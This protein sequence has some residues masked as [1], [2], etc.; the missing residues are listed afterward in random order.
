[1]EAIKRQASKFREQVSRQQQALLRQLGH[2]G[3]E[4]FVVDEAEIA[5]RDQLQKLYTST[6]AAKHFE[7]DIVQGIEGI[8]SVTSKQIE[9]ERKFAEDCS[10]YET[11]NHCSTSPLA[12]TALRVGTAR[13]SMVEEKGT[14]LRVFSEKVC[15]PLR[16]LVRSAELEDARLLIRRYNKLWQE[17]EAQAA[18]V[19][20][21]KSKSTEGAK[22]E[23]IF[24]KLHLAEEKLDELKYRLMALGKEATSA[25]LSVEAQQQKMTFQH[26]VVMM[27]AERSYHLNVLSLLEKLLAQM[28]QLE[29][30]SQSSLPEGITDSNG[31]KEHCIEY[32]DSACYVAKVVHPFDAEA[33]GELSLLVD[34]IVVVQQVIPGGWCKG[35]CNG[36]TGCFPSPYVQRLAEVSEG[37]VAWANL[38]QL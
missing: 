36:K 38:Q 33:E 24:N 8:M 20:R 11:E 13:N 2:F 34:D 25:M 6:R 5:C 37:N 18:D 9:I 31:S 22:S 16:T 28:I 4:A 15:K 35:E 3:D 32:E 7:K 30:L 26:L 27:K 29:Q 12:E 23:E 21:L 14:L 19:L 1:M 10:R 17:V